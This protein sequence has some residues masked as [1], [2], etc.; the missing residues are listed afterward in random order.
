MPE[1]YTGDEGT[2]AFE[3]GLDVLDGDEDR[4]TGWL[5]INKTRDMLVTFARDLFDSISLSWGAITGKP[6]QF[7]PTAHQHTILD[8]LTSDGTQNYGT[9]LQN[10]LDGKFPVSGGT[11][12][13]NVFLSS[14]NVYVPAA[15]PATA[16]WQP[17][18]INNDGRISRGSSSERYKKYIT[19]IDPASLGDIWPDLKRFQMRGG[20]VGAWTYGYIAERLAEHDDQRAFVVYREI[21]GELVPDSIDFMALVM[22]QNAQLHQALD[23]LAQRLDALENA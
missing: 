15:T 13:G 20:D 18:Y 6:A 22:A 11:V 8:V 14:G 17:A 7:P 19:S 10:V 2:V 1:N 3:A 12:T 21:D 16:G 4:R 23:L 9:A 5:A